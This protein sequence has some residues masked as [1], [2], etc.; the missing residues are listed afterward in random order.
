MLVGKDGLFWTGTLDLK[1][2]TKPEIIKMIELFSSKNMS[3]IEKKLK[4]REVVSGVFGGLQYRIVKANSNQVIADYNGGCLYIC[5]AQYQYVYNFFF[6]FFEI[7][8]ILKFVVAD[9][10]YLLCLDSLMARPVSLLR[11]KSFRFI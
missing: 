9:A 10:T 3:S 11:L 8:N 2:I 6:F 5:P 7:T 1:H 4:S